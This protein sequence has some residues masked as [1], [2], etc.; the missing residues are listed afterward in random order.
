MET[1]RV[2]CLER[3]QDSGEEQTV[4]RRHAEYICEVLERAT[5][6][7][8]YTPAREWGAAYR[9]F[10]DDLRS[11]LTWTGQH[12]TERLLLI[13]LTVAGNLLHRREPRAPCQGDRK[14]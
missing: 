5:N 4:R 10:L 11:A 7:W 13:R 1:T 6:E 12:P 2:Y 8:I 14:T 9:R 3:L